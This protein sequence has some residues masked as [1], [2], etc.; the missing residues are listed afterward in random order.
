[1]KYCMNQFL[2]RLPRPSVAA[3]GLKVLDTFVIERGK[4]LASPAS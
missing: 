2:P 3:A 1:M 4:P